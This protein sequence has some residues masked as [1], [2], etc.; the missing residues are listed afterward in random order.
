[1]GGLAVL[2]V[3]AAFGAPAGTTAPIEP[4][5]ALYLAQRF[6][7]AGDLPR[8]LAAFERAE[9]AV[10]SC[11]V[12]VKLWVRGATIPL[13]AASRV[14]LPVRVAR[15][16]E[17]LLERA[18]AADSVVAVRW[19]EEA[20]RLDPFDRRVAAHLV[21]VLRSL[22]KK[23]EARRVEA[24]AAQLARERPLVWVGSR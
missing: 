3:L 20:W 21:R 6:A 8:A 14:R 16:L 19:Y 15:H 12:V 1:M 7:H 18:A 23:A 13:C 4:G 9:G 24:E 22:G 2:S 10:P 5:H 11:P 17:G